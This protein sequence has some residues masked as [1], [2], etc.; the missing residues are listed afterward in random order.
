M[1][2]RSD[3]FNYSYP[4]EEGCQNACD[5]EGSYRKTEYVYGMLAQSRQCK[6]LVTENGYTAFAQQFPE[7][8]YDYQHQRQT[9]AHPQN[10]GKR[11]DRTVSAGE[12]F[13]PANIRQSPQAVK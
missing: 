6:Q 7:E 11:M 4:F 5:Q 8:G 9:Y 2:N 1:E 3:I 13:G 12:G 10:I